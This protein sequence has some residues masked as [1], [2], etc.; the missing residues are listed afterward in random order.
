VRGR[1]M[2]QLRQRGLKESVSIGY[3]ATEKETRRSDG[4]RLLKRIQLFEISL[5]SMPANP[6]AEVETVSKSFDPADLDLSEVADEL[7]RL[8]RRLRFG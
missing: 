3:R 6:L 5:T 1:I 7:Q 8:T 4:A 2:P